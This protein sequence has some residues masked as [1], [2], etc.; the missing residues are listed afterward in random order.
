M[1]EQA[2]RGSGSPGDRQRFA[3]MLRVWEAVSAERE[4][5]GVLASLA[6]VLLPAV[7]FDSIAIVDFS[8]GLE[9]H[10]KH[11]ILALHVVAFPRI[12]G[13]TAEELARRTEPYWHPLKE[14]RPL[15]AYPNSED[16][17][18]KGEP[19]ACDDLLEKEGWYDHEFSLARGGVRSYAAV[20][21]VASGRLEWPLS[22]ASCS[23]PSP[24]P[25]CQSSGTWA[26][27]CLWLPRMPSPMK[28]FVGCASKLRRRISACALN[29]ARRLGSKRYS[30]TRRP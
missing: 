15:I 2:S 3:L 26:G 18:A 8:Q 20:P 12:A 7:P 22:R 28:K 11:R 19:F 17:L 25:S 13:E 23:E 16:G 6:D 21:L 30:R 29:S 27:R 9:E 24:L 10:Q 14:E 1:F 5:H 4:L